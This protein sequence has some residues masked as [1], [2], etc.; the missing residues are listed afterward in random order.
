MKYL[1]WNNII[2]AHFFNSAN[3]GKEIHL[4][5]TK[6][7][8]VSLGRPFFY[9][10]TDD[11]IWRD[12]IT[13]IK[14]GLPG[15]NGNIITKAK[16]AYSKNNLVELKKT[17][18][19]YALIDE[20]PVL[21]PPYISY[22]TFI[23]LPLIEDVDYNNLRANNYYS[24]LNAFL[25]N[26]Q[27]NEIIKT[28]DF[29]NNQIND[30]WEN[31]AEW[32]N[33]KKNGELGLFKVIPF[34]NANW[35]YVG[36][37]FSQCVLPPKFLNRLPELF[38]SMGLVPDTF[39]DD[40]FL[41]EI[42]LNSK[43]I[44]IPKSTLDFLKNDDELSN[45][46]IQ[47][48]Q[49]QYKKWSGETHQ[50]NEEETTRKN[51]TI[52]PLILQFKINPN[53]EKIKFSYRIYSSNEYP[54]DLKF[55]EYD[56]LYEINGWSKT[57]A[58]EF[59]ENLELK[60]RFN[61]WIAKFPSRDVRLFLSAGTFQL[62]NEFWIETNILSRTERMYLL[63][64]NEKQEAIKEW[65]KTFRNGDF[66]Q[67]NFDGLP[68]NYSLF[69]FRNPTQGLHEFSILKLYTEKHI[70]LVDGLKVNFRTYSNDFLPE[71]EIKNSDGN[72]NV[73][74][75]YKGTDKKISL[76]KNP[77]ISNRWL[78]S[79]FTDLNR[80]FYIKVENE[81]FLG[82]EVAYK[83]ISGKNTAIKVDESKL[84]KRDSFGR[85]ITTDVTQYSLG[86]NI[87][88]PDSQRQ[89]P[90][91]HLF[92]STNKD[93]VDQITK[94]K[95]NNQLGNNLCE[96]L[97]LKGALTTKEYFKAFEFYYV[98]EFSEKYENFNMTKLKRASLNFYDFIGI[99]DYDY[100]TKSIILNPPQFIYIPTTRG[101]KVLLIGA[102]D[103]GLIDSIINS[104]PKHNLQ[105]EISKQF[106]SNKR[107]LLPDVIT[108]NAFQ[109]P[110]DEF[111]EKSLKAFADELQIKFID[112]TLPQVAFLNFSANITEYESIL[113]PSDENDYDWARYSFNPKTLKFEKSEEMTI[114]KS[115][116]LLQYKLNE[117]TYQNK[118]WKDNNCYQVDIN[119]GK[120]IALK[121]FK[122]NVILIDSAENKVAI[123]IDLPLPRLLAESIMLLSGF[124]PDFRVIE[125]NKYRVFEN[126]PSIFT[127]N[128]FSILGQT[129]INTIL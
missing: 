116:S 29:S 90:Y 35:I 109:Q 118:L 84:P 89:L 19:T 106:S 24:R 86:S 79:P 98:K 51:Y 115:F 119:W 36:K 66:I 75:Q 69:W 25:E 64:K 77:T 83:L 112:N 11:E 82:N 68:T 95:I 2:S 113:Q 124:A 100:E 50:E 57:I 104:A 97:S 80:D 5:L 88:N 23:V 16:F 55:Y 44:L 72:E 31:L 87:V 17:D 28:S 21:Y 20:V 94:A 110:S 49:L 41:K 102:R 126:I 4:Y 93:L 53:D 27:I 32:A 45:S 38:E 78:L 37:I 18:G 14:R 103:S 54:K 47:Q 108:I 1:E 85:K 59:Q 121:H 71:V 123:P 67:E 91:K 81:T 60:D 96:F 6:N 48:I 13:S 70:E 9:E 46:I 62:S 65:G 22:L 12:Y 111:G 122:K 63:C 73:F 117:Y 74:L 39:Y 99:L 40:N 42:I 52:A 61:K 127:T 43:T 120:F 107:L 33:V 8:I 114:D 34:Q 125:E 129:P 105:V 3:A 15:S 56:N 58:I 92:R 26:Y 7:G 101:R 128:L 10:E 30:L 76:S